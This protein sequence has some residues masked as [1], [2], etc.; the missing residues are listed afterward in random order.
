MAKYVRVIDDAA[1]IPAGSVG[2]YGGLTYRTSQSQIMREKP[3]VLV[4]DAR[5]N[6]SITLLF[7]D[8]IEEISE[9]EYFKEKLR[10]TAC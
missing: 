1:A 3:A 10:G 4:K 7:P 2:I 8:Q 5:R 9:Q 6:G